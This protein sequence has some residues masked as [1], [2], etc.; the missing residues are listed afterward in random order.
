MSIQNLGKICY[1]HPKYCAWN[2][3]L[4][5]FGL[6]TYNLSLNQKLVLYMTDYHIFKLI[7]DNNHRF[8]SSSEAEIT[9]MYKGHK[10]K[11]SQIFH[12][13]KFIVFHGWNQLFIINKTAFTNEDN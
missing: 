2:Y 13:D 12:T 9:I 1:L 8:H 6:L 4:D 7:Y 5:K 10:Q 11:I 3:M